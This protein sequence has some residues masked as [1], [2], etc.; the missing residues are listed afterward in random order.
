VKEW[1]WVSAEES[2]VCF[3]QGIPAP[4]S[5]DQQLGFEFDGIISSDDFSVYNGYPAGSQQ[6][7]LAH[8]RRHFKKV[9]SWVL[10]TQ[11]WDKS[12]WT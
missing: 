9:A 11:P 10:T 8:L 12:S 7:C 6:K 4:V 3:M 5:L 1:L 2:F